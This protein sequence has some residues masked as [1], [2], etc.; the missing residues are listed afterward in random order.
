ME[1]GP[2]RIINDFIE[3]NKKQYTIPV[4]QR[5]YEW[6]AEQCI[7]L[8]QDIVQAGKRDKTHFCGSVVYAY[9]KE[10]RNIN[11]YVLIDGQQRITTVYLLLKAMRDLA[12]DESTKDKMDAALYNIDKFNSYDVTQ[13]SKLKLKPVESDNN[14]LYLLMEEKYDKVDKSTGIWK[15][16]EL[17][18]KLVKE[19]QDKGLT[20]KQIYYGLEELTCAKIKLEDD[21]AQEIFERINSTG[22]P[23]N[24]S[25]KIRNFVLMT[26]ANQDKLYKDYWLEIEN[27]IDKKQM[28]D[29]FQDYLN[30]KIDGFAKESTA[31]DIFKNVF[32]VNDYTNESMLQ[33][34]L[35]YAKFYHAF[36]YGDEKK[37]SKQTNKTL[38]GLR[39]LKQ[40]TVFLFLFRVFEDFE[41]K[42]I[43]EPEL[44]RVL[45]FLLNYSVRRLVCEV[46]S[47]SLRGFYK[48]LYSRI[49]SKQDNKNTY[50]DSIVSFMLQL[51]TNDAIRNDDTFRQS[52]M[53]N[54][55]YRKNA[56]CKFLLSNIENQG[57]EALEIETKNLTIEHILPQNKNLSIEWQIMLGPNWELEKEKYQHTLGNLTLTGYNSELG[58]KPFSEKLKLLDSNNTKV[59]TLYKDVKDCKEW[60]S[61]TIVNRA[62]NL[63]DII[64][65]LFHIEEPQTLIS[66]TSPGF[67]EYGCDNPENAE[68]KKPNYFILQGEKI[69]CSSFATMLFSLSKRLY[70]QDSSLLEKLAKDN[71]HLIEGK[72]ASF[73]Y[74]RNQVNENTKI[75][76]TDIYISHNYTAPKLVMIISKLL[77]YYEIEQS[78][79][80]YSASTNLK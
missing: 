67:Q 20:I 50:Y 54:N 11:Y 80:V 7:K 69:N 43:S 12:E 13:Q 1:I 29:F 39:K 25:D 51:S 61:R 22:V 34:L 63:S 9:L 6:S 79:F 44:N 17:F 42:I 16:Y 45:V 46:S 27:L 60:N 57:K 77:D 58:D 31:Y 3:P 14:Q 8:F 4:Y 52:L 33:E 65:K 28:S 68:Y 23:L 19:E 15:N 66:F 48:T 59:V 71:V 55:L 21:N 36:L 26:D 64:L 37:Y 30:L 73:S 2:G 62:N 53:D 35:H 76:G 72:Y 74:D 70:E 47:N 49:F 41:N 18:S 10:E 75:E 24:L 56:L 38:N 78:D 40:T 5:N 32:K